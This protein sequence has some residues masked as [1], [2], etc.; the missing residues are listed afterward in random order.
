M[1]LNLLTLTLY[2]LFTHE[3]KL[4]Y[5]LLV[6]L[7]CNYVVYVQTGNRNNILPTHIYNRTSRG[8]FF[9]A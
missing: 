3:Y 5:K 8:I 6:Y 1:T 2:P 7:A 4:R 9:N